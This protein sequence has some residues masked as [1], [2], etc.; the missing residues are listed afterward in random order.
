MIEVVATAGAAPAA[1][2]ADVTLG[3]VTVRRPPPRNSSFLSTGSLGTLHRISC[4]ML[5]ELPEEV[6]RLRLDNRGGARACGRARRAK[7]ALLPLPGWAAHPPP[8]AATRVASAVLQRLLAAHGRPRTLP[9]TLPQTPTSRRP[10]VAQGPVFGQEP[11]GPPPPLLHAAVPLLAAG[12]AQQGHARARVGAH[13]LGVA[14]PAQVGRGWGAGWAR[15]CLRRGATPAGAG[16]TDSIPAGSPTQPAAAASTV[17]ERAAAENSQSSSLQGAPS[18]RRPRST[19]L[20]LHRPCSLFVYI[21][22]PTQILW[23]VKVPLMLNMVVAALVILNEEVCSGFL[24]CCCIGR[25]WCLLAQ[26][27]LAQLSCPP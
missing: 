19:P 23:K 21:G 27:W 1:A 7:P 13:P 15:A 20:P 8:A 18:S 11:A 5:P 12:H 3:P 4:Q 25:G 14:V 24:S 16:R 2:H 17:P 26:R 22:R 10:L 6:I 9:R